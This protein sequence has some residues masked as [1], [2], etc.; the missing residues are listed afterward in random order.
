MMGI[1]RS[2]KSTW[3]DQNLKECAILC[4]DDIRLAM[5]FKFLSS[6]EPIVDFVHQ[7]AFEAMMRR[8]AR[9]C[10]DSTHTNIEFINKI[11]MISSKYQYERFF[12]HMDTPIG[13]CLQRNNGPKKVPT[14]V[15]HRK[16]AEL[17]QTLQSIPFN[18]NTV[19]YV[20]N[21]QD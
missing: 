4:R 1:P 2:G 12:I 9:I 19:T 8:G 20:E 11:Y 10:L 3:A 21:T 17:K 13:I 5:G 15:I 18:L 7:M 14:N 16:H 6:M